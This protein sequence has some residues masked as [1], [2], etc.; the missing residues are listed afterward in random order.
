MLYIHFLG[1]G[2]FGEFSY[3]QKTPLQRRSQLVGVGSLGRRRFMK[4]FYVK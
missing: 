1:C 4:K 2:K 3:R